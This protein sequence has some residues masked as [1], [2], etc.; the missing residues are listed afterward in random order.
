MMSRVAPAPAP[1]PSTSS[2]A[3]PAEASRATLVERRERNHPTRD[4][5]KTRGERPSRRNSSLKEEK[6]GKILL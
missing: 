5:R 3:A 6:C 1:A 4:E 2:S